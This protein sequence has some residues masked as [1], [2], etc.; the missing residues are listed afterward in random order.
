MLMLVMNVGVMRVAVRD[1]FVGVRMRMRFGA[2]PREIVGVLVMDVVHVA[3][4]MGDGL[5]LVHV[6]VALAQVQPHADAHQYG[7]NPEEH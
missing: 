4:G 7:C 5:V 1:G 6:F 3:V 2:I